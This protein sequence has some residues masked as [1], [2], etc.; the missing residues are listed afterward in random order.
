MVSIGKSVGDAVGGAFKFVINGIIDK[1]EKIVN[2]P[3]KVINKLIG[4]IQTIIPS[5]KRLDEFSL[6]R[7]KTGMSYVPKDY[8]PAFLDEGER[9]LTKEQNAAFN[10]V[11]G[12]SGLIN[13]QMNDVTETK[14]LT[15]DNRI[16]DYLE[17]IANKNMSFYVDSEKL[18]EVTADNDD[19]ISGEKI[20]L[21]NRGL[22][23]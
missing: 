20:D 1:V 19:K 5:L 14:F 16:Y 22:E 18:A 10:R 4:K 7:L 23:L 21:K 13:S 8:F 2:A 15:G 11:G 6:P 9:V 12:L 3:I 17:R